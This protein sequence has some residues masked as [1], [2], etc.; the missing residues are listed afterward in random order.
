MRVYLCSRGFG[1]QNRSAAKR[2]F[3][4]VAAFAESALPP[5]QTDIFLDRQRKIQTIVSM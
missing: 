2:I 1:Q 5:S 3:G 4:R